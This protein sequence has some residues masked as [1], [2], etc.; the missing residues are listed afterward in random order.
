MDKLLLVFLICKK[1]FFFQLGNPGR[2]RIHSRFVGTCSSLMSTIFC[3]CA[4]LISVKHYCG[5]SILVGYILDIQRANYITCNATLPGNTVKEGPPSRTKWT[6]PVGLLVWLFLV[7]IQMTSA[8][9]GLLACLRKKSE[10]KLVTLW[11]ICWSIYLTER[12]IF[13]FL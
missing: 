10:I 7:I 12:T 4:I 9:A 6:F 13:N 2:I 3:W 8:S 1:L 11:P 5:L